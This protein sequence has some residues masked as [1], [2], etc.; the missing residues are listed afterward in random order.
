MAALKY[1]RFIVKMST[2]QKVRL[3]T[4]TEFYKS[5]SVGNYEFPVFEIKNLPFDESCKG[6]H[7]THFPCDKALACSWNTEL[8]GDV[9][10]AVGEEARAVNSF[11]YFNCSNDVERENLTPDHYVLSRFLAEKIS[12]LRRGNAYVNFEDTDAEY[13]D[14]QDLR[15]AVRD[16]V[17]NNASPTS[18]VFSDITE[19]EAAVKRFKYGDLVYGI[20]STVDEALDFLY[21]GAS[22]LFLSADVTA[23]LANRLT[24][25]VEAYKQAHTRFVND[26][27]TESSFARLVRNFRIFDGEI[28]D[29]ACDKV[30][31]IVFSMQ[32]AK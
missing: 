31:D 21:S 30:I 26:K 23:A 15:R 6:V 17:L 10:A 25:L 5:S 7:A 3:I 19:A 29:R 8:V 24:S 27:M 14:E 1:E 12:G 11:A 20:A 16:G 9:Y 28:L 2:E 4:S 22:F 13:G 18:V 32:S